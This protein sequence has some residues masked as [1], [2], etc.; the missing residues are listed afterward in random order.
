[1]PRDFPQVLL[2]PA[3]LAMGPLVTSCNRRVFPGLPVPLHPTRLLLL[4][5]KQ[6]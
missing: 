2:P 6:H 5:P 4:I 1:M 3:L